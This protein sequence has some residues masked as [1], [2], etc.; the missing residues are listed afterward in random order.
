MVEAH[1]QACPHCQSR[2]RDFGEVDRVIREGMS[3]SDDQVARAA[4]R[5]RLRTETLPRARPWILR[6]PLVAASVAAL[7]LLVPLS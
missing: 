3:L 1:L 6:R 2:L 7:A 4:L 5:A